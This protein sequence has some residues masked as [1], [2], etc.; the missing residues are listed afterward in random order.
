MKNE[1][2]LAPEYLTYAQLSLL[3]NLPI[4]TCYSLVSKKRIPFVRFGRR[5][6]RFRRADIEAW[7]ADKSRR[8]GGQ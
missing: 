2:D 5:L 4:G 6:I 3:L 1:I 7:V 8:E